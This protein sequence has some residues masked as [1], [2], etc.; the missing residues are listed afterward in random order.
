MLMVKNIKALG[1]CLFLSGVVLL[2]QK[3]Y[4][5]CAVG[6]CGH[7]FFI[8]QWSMLD[9]PAIQIAELMTIAVIILSLIGL[10]IIRMKGSKK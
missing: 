8:I 5:D 4:A 7:T 9:S 2:S 10:F 3:V 6:Y 1:I